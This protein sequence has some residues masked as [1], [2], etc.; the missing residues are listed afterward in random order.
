[1]SSSYWNVVVRVPYW[2]G[3][4]S[5]IAIVLVITAGIVTR[6]FGVE[7]TGL[8]TLAQL[9]GV[10]LGFI[11]VGAVAYEHRHI[12]IDNFTRGLTGRIE[13]A[14]E[15]AVLLCN[16]LFTLILVDGGMRA[17]GQFWDSTAP[18]PL[19][20]GGIETPIPI[21]L[22]YLAIVLG[23]GLVSLVYVV[24]L[25]SF[26]RLNKYLPQARGDEYI[27]QL[28]AE[29]R[30]PEAAQERLND[31]PN[32]GPASEDGQSDGDRTGENGA[33]NAESADEQHD[34]SS[35]GGQQ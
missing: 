9:V 32:G 23:F 15:V 35:Q 27:D 14:H 24:D 12:E 4:A 18:S 7:A 16:L 21:P 5:V 33:A 17:M 19:G 26:T 10:W 20:V 22:Y 31:E 1:M 28:K 30:A 8:Q 25:A 11:I 6:N 2:I 29:S 34:E 3:G 13:T